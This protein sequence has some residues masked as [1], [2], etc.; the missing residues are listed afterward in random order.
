MYTLKSFPS[1]LSDMAVKILAETSINDLRPGS[2]ILTLLEAIANEDAQQYIAMLNLLENFNLD[3]TSGD[4]LTER[5]YEAGL[6]RLTSTSASGYIAFADSAVI[7]RQSVLYAASPA[8]LS[9]AVSIDVELNSDIA[10]FPASGNVIIGRGTNNNETVA[11]SSITPHSDY[12]T[13]NLPIGTLNTHGTEETVILSQGGSRVVPVGTEISVP[14][15]DLSRK[16][17]F[18]TR[19]AATILD[20]E[21]EVTD[22]LVVCSTTG[23][24]GNVPINAISSITSP[25]ISTISVSN[26]A[27]FTNG[28]D[29]ESD[30]ELRD[31][32]RSTIQA[33]SLGTQ[34]AVLNKI[35]RISDTSDNKSVISSTYIE[36]TEFDK[37]SF[38]YIDDGTGFEPSWQGLGSEEV[39]VEAAGTERFLNLDNFPIMKAAL[40]TKNSEPYA[41]TSG[42]QLEIWVGDVSEILTISDTAF[43]NIRAATAEEVA[44][45]IN[46]MS[47]LVEARTTDTGSKVIITPITSANDYIKVSGGTA[48]AILAFTTNQYAYDLNLYKNDILLSKDGNTA[49]VI[50][51]NSEPFNLAGS[52]TLKYTV[53]GKT[54]NIIT[55]TFSASDFI[56]SYNALASEVAIAIN[57]QAIGV[58]ATATSDGK[59]K[60]SA[61]GAPSSSSQVAIDITGTSNAEFGFSVVPPA[62]T[63]VGRDKDYTLNRYNGQI[64]LNSPLATLDTVTAGTSNTRAFLRCSSPEMYIIGGADILRI[65]VDGNVTPLTHSFATLGAG[66]Y[67]AQTIVDD[68][69]SDPIMAGITAFIKTIATENYICIRT[70]TQDRSVGSILIDVATAPSLDMTRGVLISNQD[71]SMGY[72]ESESDTFTIGRNQNLVIVL[73]NDSVNRIWN[74]NLQSAGT[75]TSAISDT[76]FADSSL[77]ATY[78]LDDCFV[79]SIIQFDPTTATTALRNQKAT[80]SSYSAISGTITTS[81]SLP[82]VPSSGDTFAI[83]P[84]TA[85]NVVDLLTNTAFTSLSAFADIEVSRITSNVQITTKKLGTDGAV[86]IA[87]GTA[88]S[89]SIA[90]ASNGTAVG[91]F[92]VNTI[93]GL[94]EGLEPI[95]YDN[96]PTT[97][98][99][100]YIHSLTG[101][102]APYTVSVRNITPPD[103]SAFTVAAGGSITSASPAVLFTDDGTSGG[104]FKIAAADIGT[105]AVGQSITIDKTVSAPIN[106]YIRSISG[107]SGGKYTITIETAP[108]LTTLSI[109]DSALIKDKAGLGF[110]TSNFVGVDAYKYYTGLLREVQWQI[111]GLDSD[112]ENYPGIKAAGTHLEVKAPVIKLMA[113]EIDIT[114]RPG[115]EL[116]DVSNDVKSTVASYVNGSGV[117]SDIILSEIIAAIHNINLI[118]DVVIKYPISNVTIQDTELPRTNET[119]ITLG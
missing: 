78:S 70:N 1:I 11:Y 97:I 42:Q 20:G 32:I 2:V 19:E 98:N 54:G 28:H 12:V 41:L 64:E 56:D 43:Q 75:V 87:G 117:G 30:Q 103:I 113:F 47:N 83:Y 67:S 111:D 4:D 33:L 26:N 74:I 101:G 55:I 36:A 82:A 90:F 112:P 16:I 29:N 99:N 22:I 114:T 46:D 86:Q 24:V 38:V 95:I 49:F 92:E 61:L 44:A 72:S 59:I 31:R 94:S 63:G 3:S 39:I 71:P 65:Y 91:T 77:S 60:I 84:T 52:P 13:L 105:L 6:D 18:T 118:S 89:F 109:S 57:K 66:T 62:T 110:L 9:G 10:F 104:T 96:T 45:H 40:V 14:A 115:T 76:I 37:P 34:T 27:P 48:N 88:N 100:I 8:P 58:I 15:T 106:G 69:N 5:A 80:I 35:A 116:A 93:T 102:S 51:P 23:S 73:D 79:D 53:D 108:D 85:A 81:S 21:S 25:P 119:L 107:P 50:S 17:S 7:K 68:I